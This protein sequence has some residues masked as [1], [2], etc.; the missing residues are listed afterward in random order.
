MRRRAE[1]KTGAVG[2]ARP[3]VVGAVRCLARLVL[4]VECAGC[5]SRDAVLCAACASA[6]SGPVVRCEAGAPRWDRMTG[7]PAPIWAAASY[8]GPVRGTVVAWKDKG[9]ADLTGRLHRALAGAVAELAVGAWAED[10]GPRRLVVVPVPSSPAARRRRGDDLVAGLA[11]VV[12][13]TATEHG[14]AVRAVPALQ[15]RRGATDQVGLGTRARG[16]NLAGA[17]RVRRRGGG[18]GRGP[19]PVVGSGDRVL[20][21]DDVVTT[22]ATLAACARALEGVGAVVVGAVVLAATPSPRGG[23]RTAQPSH[24]GRPGHADEVGTIVLTSH[25]SRGYG[26]ARPPGERASDGALPSPVGAEGGGA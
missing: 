8:V 6:W 7:E 1:R 13:A 22:G 16:R 2:R 4:P 20:L 26:G 3:A 19:A 11:D 23:A 14:L 15:R 24:A 10:G 25:E 18:R 9:R 5:G 21:V 17:V 12:A